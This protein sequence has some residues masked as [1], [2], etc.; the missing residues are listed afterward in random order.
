ML[1]DRFVRL[2]STLFVSFFGAFS[3][4][5]FTVSEQALE[6]KI[7]PD[8]QKSTHVSDEGGD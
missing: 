1:F 6:S 2:F 3:L 5:L 7:M 4:Q 8:L